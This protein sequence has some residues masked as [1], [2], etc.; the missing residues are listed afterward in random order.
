MAPHEL[1]WDGENQPYSV[2]FGDHFYSTHDGRAECRHVFLAGNGLPDRWNRTCPFTIA[3]LGF[4]TGLNFLE[5]WRLWQTVRKPEQLLHFVSFEAHPLTA[6]DV[7]RAIAQWSDL[8]TL[9]EQL[10][11]RWSDLTE[12]SSCIS[13][14][15]QTSLTLIVGEAGNRVASWNGHADAW[16]LDGFAPARNPDMWSE[17]LMRAVFDHTRPGGT[18]ATYTAA[19][20][21]RRNLQNAGFRVSKSIGFKGKRH[22]MH[23]QKD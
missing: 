4:G 2:S 13:M 20:W 6:P 5:T 9:C 3:E 16:F 18:F 22:M 10:V 1:T 21:A 11:M 7:T 23:G 17:K 12:A 19:G 15:A 14:D 8:G